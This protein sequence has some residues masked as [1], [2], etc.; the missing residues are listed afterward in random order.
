MNYNKILIIYNPWKKYEGSLLEM[1]T[2]AI[3]T[4]SFEYDFID[5]YTEQKYSYTSWKDKGIN[6]YQRLFN[7]NTQYYLTLENKYFNKIFR[8]KILDFKKKNIEHYDYVLIIKPEDYSP[9]NIK[10]LSQL[11]E[12]TVGYIWDGL[13]IFFKSNIDQSRS[14]LDELYSFDTNNINDYP[15]L[16]MQ[17]CTNFY[18]PIDNIIS[19]KERHIDLFFVGDLAGTLDRQRR[20]KKLVKFLK[21]INGELDINIWINPSINID[22]IDDKKIKYTSKH[23][24]MS[25]AFE[26]TRNSKAVIDICKAH[27]I[28]LSFRFF[29]CLATETKIITNNK[30]VINYDF[31]N[32][33]NILIVD[34]DKDILTTKLFYDFLNEPF[35][36]LSQEIIEKYTIENWLKYMFKIEGH[37]KI[38]KL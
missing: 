11:G 9:Q 36:K 5:F 1:I 32:P 26:K 30:D 35:S 28:G 16:K 18:T 13:R 31:Y 17:F 2:S 12:K 6:I 20:D 22:K 14:Y 33:K 19:Y 25:F 8:S 24:P 29:E 38:E 21:E 27:H 34:F 4:T 15:E 37:K 3:D 10:E 7:K 23:I